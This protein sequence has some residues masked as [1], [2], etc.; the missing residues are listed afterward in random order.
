MNRRLL[1]RLWMIGSALW[2]AYAGWLMGSRT[3]FPD[4]NLLV[5][6][7]VTLAP[8]LGV[9]CLGYAVAWAARAFRP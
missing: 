8:P 5:S 6:A 2:I 3:T 1:F 4:P 9:L 7:V